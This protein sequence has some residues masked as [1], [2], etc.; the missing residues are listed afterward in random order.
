MD[1]IKGYDKFFEMASPAVMSEEINIVSAHISDI[2]STVSIPVS[3]A[4]L[5]GETIVVK[6]LRGED[7]FVSFEKEAGELKIV[8]TTKDNAAALWDMVQ[9]ADFS[10]KPNPEAVMLYLDINERFGTLAGFMQEITNQ[11]GL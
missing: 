1:Y 2:Y 11:V 4:D 5:E 10:K 7:Y 8:V 3:D 6:A 9:I